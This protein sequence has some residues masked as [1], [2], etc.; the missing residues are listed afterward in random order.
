MRLICPNCGAQYDVPDGAIPPAGREVQCSSCG[1]AW[2]EIETPEPAAESAPIPPEAPLIAPSDPSKETRDL[3]QPIDAN[4][5]AI[6]R[7]EAAR[8]RDLTPPANET[9]DETHKPLRRITR[10]EDT[11]KK[12][13][14]P[15]PAIV[16]VQPDPGPRDMPSMDE[17]N[18]NLRARSLTA[19][20]SLTES[21]QQEVVA[22]RGFRYGFGLMLLI[23]A[24]L[25]L[26]YVFADQI[27]A[28]L[29]QLQDG[30]A[31][32]VALID[33]LRITLNQ[34]VTDIAARVAELMNGAD[35]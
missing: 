22:R 4:V 23:F 6:L 32:Y 25:L 3:R 18:A 35:A 30:M 21:E 34:G 28:A 13:P 9:E 33:Q 27:T 1:H 26:P 7:E 20:P 5:K 2:F 16:P 24:I 15:V 8:D 29:P 14:A 11:S 19:R 10:D 31:S 12:P 17:I